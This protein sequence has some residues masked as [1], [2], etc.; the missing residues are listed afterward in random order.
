MTDRGDGKIFFVFE[1]AKPM[2]V[3]ARE[4]NLE[5]Q[6]HTLSIGVLPP[7]KL[8]RLEAGRSD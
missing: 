1:T 3:I 4:L 5:L 2:P 6:L 8:E 7:L